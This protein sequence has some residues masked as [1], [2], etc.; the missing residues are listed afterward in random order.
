MT[1][2]VQ[3]VV[4]KFTA[5]KIN[6]YEGGLI[7]SLHDYESLQLRSNP[8]NRLLKLLDGK[9]NHSTRGF[10]TF[11]LTLPVWKFVP[12]C[13]VLTV[14]VQHRDT[15]TRN[16]NVAIVA[17]SFFHVPLESQ[18][19]WRHFFRRYRDTWNM[20]TIYRGRV[21]ATFNALCIKDLC[22]ILH[23]DYSDMKY[24]FLVWS[25]NLESLDV[26][27]IG[28]IYSLRNAERE[29]FQSICNSYFYET[30]WEIRTLCTLKF[31]TK[32]RRIRCL[33]IT[34][35]IQEFR[36]KLIFKFHF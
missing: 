4:L 15:L 24:I 13:F 27:R 33:G 3:N 10:L 6:K 7:E 12:K 1:I 34:L 26:K 32:S 20:G 29:I 36:L 31:F 30:N 5:T 21:K 19:V 23:S 17:N 28:C 18:S 25:S 22:V 14:G 2:F 35:K 11:D 8:V 16:T 9:L